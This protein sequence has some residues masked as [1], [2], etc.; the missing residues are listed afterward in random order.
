MK[1]LHSLSPKEKEK[2]RQSIYFQWRTTKCDEINEI[3]NTVG[4]YCFSNVGD[5]I[6]VVVGKTPHGSENLLYHELWHAIDKKLRVLQDPTYQ[7]L[8][9]L[10]EQIP[11]DV[12]NPYYSISWQDSTCPNHLAPKIRV[13]QELFAEY[14]SW[15]MAKK[16]IQHYSNSMVENSIPDEIFYISAYDEPNNEKNEKYNDIKKFHLQMIQYLQNI[17]EKIKNNAESAWQKQG[18][19]SPNKGVPKHQNKKYCLNNTPYKKPKHYNT[20]TYKRV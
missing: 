9:L 18:N 5:T 14:R 4:A 7:D 10:Y 1:Y 3:L 20:H 12:K 6:Y 11:N 8:L 17:E 2:F 19:N 16:Y 15:Y 13:A